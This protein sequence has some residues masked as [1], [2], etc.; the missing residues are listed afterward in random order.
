MSDEIAEVSLS[1][2][3]LRRENND[4]HAAMFD[5]L[6]EQNK[7]VQG[8]EKWQATIKG[9]GMAIKGMWIVTTGLIGAGGAVLAMLIAQ[10]VGK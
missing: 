9:A 7:R 1:L 4:D 8:L 2:R 3:E 6:R 10:I 5:L